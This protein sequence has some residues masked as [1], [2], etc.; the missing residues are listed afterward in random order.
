MDKKEIFTYFKNNSSYFKEISQEDISV[1]ENLE[2]DELGVMNPVIFQ[3]TPL[4]QQICRFALIPN[5]LYSTEVEE[6][7]DVVSSPS[8]ENTIEDI[9]EFTDYCSCYV[10]FL[11]SLDCHHPCV[12]NAVNSLA[13][14]YYY[15]QVQDTVCDLISC[16]EDVFQNDLINCVHDTDEKLL[17]IVDFLFNRLKKQIKQ[18][19][20]SKE[21]I[22]KLLVDYVQ[23]KLLLC[24]M[25]GVSDPHLQKE[26][27][28]YYIDN[29]YIYFANQNSIYPGYQESTF[30]FLNCFSQLMQ[31]V[32]KYQDYYYGGSDDETSDLIIQLQNSYSL[33]ESYRYKYLKDSYREQRLLEKCK[34]M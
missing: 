15:N 11:S 16:T 33:Y 30:Q 26:N 13:H 3:I 9:L 24:G 1:L 17:N 21:T 6:M 20:N 14:M 8:F 25:F 32:E 10:D 4:L 34:K 23:N 28:I 29:H 31:K 19:L 22:L 5:A 7:M 2:A 12:M 27:A 18:N